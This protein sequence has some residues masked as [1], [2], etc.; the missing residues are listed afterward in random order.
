MCD[1][2][3]HAHQKAKSRQNISVAFSSRKHE[4]ASWNIPTTMH[5]LFTVRNTFT[6]T[7]VIQHIS[8]MI[9][10]VCSS[11][12][13]LVVQCLMSFNCLNIS[14]VCGFILFG[15]SYFSNLKYIYL[16]ALDSDQST[17]LIGSECTC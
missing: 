13:S 12:Q 11:V 10:T 16:F 3:V 9:P 1:V 14:E 17:A 2:C 5:Y 15:N 7:L 6:S 8:S 4:N